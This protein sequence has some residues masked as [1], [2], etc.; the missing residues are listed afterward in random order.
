MSHDERLR[1][2]P[3]WWLLATCLVAVIAVVLFAYVPTRVSVAVSVLVA[4]A[5]A[6]V[7]WGWGAARVHVEDGWLGVGRCRIEGRYLAGAEP[8]D[9][10]QAAV[11]LGQQA[12]HR[13]FLLTRPYIAPAVRVRIDDPADPHPHWI[14]SSRR[15][16]QLAAAINEISQG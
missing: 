9:P 12:D 3:L 8:L 10:Q 4:V 1:V 13:D 5:A 14:V 16:Q 11:S 6:V 2:P 15:P 7:L